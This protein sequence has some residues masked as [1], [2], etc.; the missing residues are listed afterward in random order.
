MHTRVRQK[1]FSHMTSML[2]GIV[3]TCLQLPVRRWSINGQQ[4]EPSRSIIDVEYHRNAVTCLTAD[5]LC[6]WMF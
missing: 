5:G 3:A 2:W 6:L 4:A 1:S